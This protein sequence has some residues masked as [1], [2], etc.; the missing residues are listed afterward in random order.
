MKDQIVMSKTNGQLA[1]CIPLYR[2]TYEDLIGEQAGYKMMLT[3]A[4]PHPVA[5]VIDCGFACQL[6][7]PKFVKKHLVFLGD[8]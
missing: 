1:V 4:G 6:A 3:A 8:L 5:W 2:I 7:N